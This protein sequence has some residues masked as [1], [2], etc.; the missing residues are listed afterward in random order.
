MEYDWKS[1]NAECAI[2]ENVVELGSRLIRGISMNVLSSDGAVLRLGERLKDYQMG[3]NADEE[4]V[5]IIRLFNQSKRR[6][7]EVDAIVSCAM[8]KNVVSTAIQG[9][10]GTVKE[11]VSDG[12]V[13][14]NLEF[15][16]LGSEGKYPQ[17]A[18]SAVMEVLRLNDTLQVDSKVLNGIWGV[19][20][21]VVR[22]V[23]FSPTIA[24]DYQRF[25]VALESDENYV[26]EE[27][28]LK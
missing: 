24:F 9:L 14:I 19:T 18:V 12:D 20:R 28:L 3:S 8:T 5:D 1:H 15:T 4:V 17:D 6:S 10:A 27:D 13:A 25:S 11:W 26:I 2:K 23:S 22:S 16:L 21:V 7:I